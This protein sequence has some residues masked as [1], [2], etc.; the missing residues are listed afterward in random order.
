MVLRQLC[1]PHQE[2]V[3]AYAVSEFPPTMQ[4]GKDWNPTETVQDALLKIYVS[5]LKETMNILNRY[6]W[7]KFVHYDKSLNLA[8]S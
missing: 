4:Y 2:Q 6:L 7:L 8:C 1:L 3:T 5:F